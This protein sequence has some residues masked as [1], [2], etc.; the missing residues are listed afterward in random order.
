[1]NKKL[2]RR[3]FL[4]VAGVASAGLALSACGVKATEMPTL[5]A[6]VLPSPT[7]TITAIP[8]ITPTPTPPL[9]A[10]LR[11][12]LALKLGHSFQALTLYY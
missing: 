8:T 3:D 5:T 4:K 2:S 6:T 12:K 1:M 9:S 10:L 7:A 11:T